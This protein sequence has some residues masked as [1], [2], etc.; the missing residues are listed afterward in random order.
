MNHVPVQVLPPHEAYRFFPP[1]EEKVLRIGDYVQ[2]LIFEGG[3]EYNEEEW[4]Y[5]H[6]F[7]DYLEENKVE[8][9]SGLQLILDHPR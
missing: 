3:E 9:S 5:I 7:E 8:V 1:Q 6:A 4:D 2:R